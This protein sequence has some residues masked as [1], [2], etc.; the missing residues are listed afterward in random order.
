MKVL[1]SDEMK[2]IKGRECIAQAATGGIIIY[3]YESGNSNKV[4][5][6]FT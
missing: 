3:N 5:N 6:L 2:S 4:Q 1:I